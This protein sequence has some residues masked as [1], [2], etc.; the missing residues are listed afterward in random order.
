M[1]FLNF[2][3]RDVQRVWVTSL[4]LLDDVVVEFLMPRKHS[5]VVIN[6]MHIFYLVVRYPVYLLKDFLILIYLLVVV[7]TYLTEGATVGTTTYWFYQSLPSS[8]R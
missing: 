6:D 3:P 4:R 7:F 1:W 2:R 5:V 8:F